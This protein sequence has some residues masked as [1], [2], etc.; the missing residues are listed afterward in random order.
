MEFPPVRV[1]GN[2]LA[3]QFS[4]RR[5]LDRQERQPLAGILSLDLL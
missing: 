3:A 2:E 1:M 5:F 4:G